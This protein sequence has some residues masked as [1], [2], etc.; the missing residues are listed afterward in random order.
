MINRKKIIIFGTLTILTLLTISV[1]TAMTTNTQTTRK[2]SPLYTIRNRLAIREQVENI[3]TNF[4]Q[5]DRIFIIPKL[6]LR[7]ETGTRENLPPCTHNTGV[8]SCVNTNFG[9]CKIEVVRQ[10]FLPPCTTQTGSGFTMCVSTGKC[11]YT[12]YQCPQ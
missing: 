11:E 8:S 3:V 4:L 1:V 12:V 2:E 7:A 5:R 9:C 6:F 10:Q